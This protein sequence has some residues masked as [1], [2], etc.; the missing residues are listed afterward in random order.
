MLEQNTLAAAAASY[1]G[2]GFAGC[3]FKI[4]AT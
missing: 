2:K 3:D 4:D 1:D